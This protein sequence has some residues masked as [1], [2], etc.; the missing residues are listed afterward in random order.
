MMQFWGKT[1][2]QSLFIVFTVKAAD[3]LM[4][5]WCQARQLKIKKKNFLHLINT[6][7]SKSSDADN[8]VT[9]LDN[10]L[11][12]NCKALNPE[13]DIIFQQDGISSYTS[14]ERQRLFISSKCSK[15]HFK[16]LKWQSCHLTLPYWP[17]RFDLIIKKY[18][19]W[20]AKAIYKAQTS[21]ESN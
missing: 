18:V 7:Y 3:L 21:E 13:D 20:L 14:N 17:C 19:S 4:G 11:F 15:F 1:S 16:K 6:T 10:K 5:K 9:M 12:P 8:N 2:L